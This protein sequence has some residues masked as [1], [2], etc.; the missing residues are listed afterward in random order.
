MTS[1]FYYSSSSQKENGFV[2]QIKAL[3]ENGDGSTSIVLKNA[4]TLPI[5]SRDDDIDNSVDGALLSRNVIIEGQSGEYDKGGYMQVLHTPGIA[6][7][8]QGAMFSNMGRRTEVDRFVSI[9]CCPFEIGI[10]LH[11]IFVPEY[12]HFAICYILGRHHNCYI[13]ET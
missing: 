12:S 9:V 5:I 3:T 6:Q 1:S 10:F 7:S 2:S 11:F 8:I 4:A 13:L